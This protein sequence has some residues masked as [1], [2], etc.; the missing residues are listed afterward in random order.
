MDFS[1]QGISDALTGN[2]VPEIVT[3]V[4]GVL[5]LLIVI[6]YLKNKE[7]ITYKFMVFL[8]LIVGVLLIIISIRVYGT[9]ELYSTMI[10][11]V[12]GFT[13]IIR[14][15]REVDFAVIVTLLV[16]AVVYVSLSGLDGGSLDVL[17]SGWPQV[18]ATVVVGM[19]VYMALHFLQAV[20]K[21]FGKLLNW[22]PVL[23]ILGIICIIEA[24]A[25][26][27]GYGSIYD[28]FTKVSD[29]VAGISF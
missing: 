28:Y 14:P 20:V 18:I 26:Y 24:L 16:M 17:S 19:F 29:V 23:M 7:S 4:A 15:F 5:A 1:F 10:V 11:I 22:W 6:T 8:G 2:H 12:A 25:V 13:L 9:W 21:L 3:A 27:Q